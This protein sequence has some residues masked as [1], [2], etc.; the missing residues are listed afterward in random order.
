M[1]PGRVS[2]DP[3]SEADV[4]RGR[5]VTTN[6]PWDS[7]LN[8]R[9][10]RRA[11]PAYLQQGR[12]HDR[13]RREAVV[14]DLR[15][16]LTAHPGRVS[17]DPHMK[18]TSPATAAWPAA[19]RLQLTGRVSRG[20]HQEAEAVRGRGSD[21]GL[22]LHAQLGFEPDELVDAVGHGGAQRPHPARRMRAGGGKGDPRPTPLRCRARRRAPRPPGNATVGTRS[23]IP[24][25]LPSRVRLGGAQVEERG[26]EGGKEDLGRTSPRRRAHGKAPRPPNAQPGVTRP[27]MPP[28]LP[29]SSLGLA[30]SARI[31]PSSPQREQR[32]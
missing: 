25:H 28:L 16:K 12:A 22:V 9:T 6:R 27:S 10:R 32:G 23:T 1:P 2:R 24:P 15:S 29:I 14:H 26:H 8:A 4:A 13:H 30:G 20:H 11:G 3:H 31:R 18:P 19:K 5:G 7:P 21:G 17:R